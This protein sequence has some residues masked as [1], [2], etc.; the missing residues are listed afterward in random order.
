[1]T[2]RFS[3][4]IT[5]LIV[6]LCFCI[7][8]SIIKSS[9]HGRSAGACVRQLAKAMSALALYTLI[10]NPLTPFGE[11]S[12][13]TIFLQSSKELTSRL[14]IETLVRTAN[15]TIGTY[16]SK[17]P[18]CRSSSSPENRQSSR[19]GDQA[20]GT[21]A[22]NYAVGSNCELMTCQRKV[23][24]GCASISEQEGQIPLDV[25]RNACI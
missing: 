1:M 3:A 25:C 16:S 6:E 20:W 19:I 7:L 12:A 15:S 5:G 2:I 23:S 24:D 11:K 22:K 14:S 10:S 4:R 9:F 21:R 8:P 17:G 18:C 13:G